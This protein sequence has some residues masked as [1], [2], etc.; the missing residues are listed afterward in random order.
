MTSPV[1]NYLERDFDLTHRKC[2]GIILLPQ[3]PIDV[4]FGYLVWLK[5]VSQLQKQLIIEVNMRNALYRGFSR[6]LGTLPR[7]YADMPVEVCWSTLLSNDL[8][9]KK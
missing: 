4:S 8:L 7:I 5:Q 9:F 6:P 1:M 3:V 2:L